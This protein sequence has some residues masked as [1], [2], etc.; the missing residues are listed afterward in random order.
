M[1]RKSKAEHTKRWSMRDVGIESAALRA[2][3]EKWE[4]QPGTTL[5]ITEA[6]KNTQV[7]DIDNDRLAELLL[8][9]QAVLIAQ[10]GKCEPSNRPLQ[11]LREY[12]EGLDEQDRDLAMQSQGVQLLVAC[13]D[14]FHK[15]TL[16]D[17]GDKLAPGMVWKYIP[18]RSLIDELVKRDEEPWAQLVRGKAIN[19]EALA[20]LLRQYNIHPSHA[21]DRRTRGYFVADFR[22]AWSRYLPPFLN[23]SNPSNPSGA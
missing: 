23:P 4:R 13:R 18:T 15:P 7:F 8:P 16:G 11:V 6:Y 9:L 1:K 3:L 22:D 21:E 20:S 2:E 5:K 14:I 12:A 17:R 19:A 10:A